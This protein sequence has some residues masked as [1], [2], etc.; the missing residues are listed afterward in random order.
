MMPMVGKRCSQSIINMIS[1]VSNVSVVSISTIIKINLII[2][3]INLVC[4]KN[5]ISTV[6]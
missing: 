4:G 2:K 5:M 6:A 3:M 1:N